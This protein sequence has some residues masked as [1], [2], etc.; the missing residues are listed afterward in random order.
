M[1]EKCL[2]W[3]YGTAMEGLGTENMDLGDGWARL[4]W[5]QGFWREWECMDESIRVLWLQREGLFKGF[6]ELKPLPI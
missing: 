2:G 1:V 3:V 5:L 6:Q 4:W